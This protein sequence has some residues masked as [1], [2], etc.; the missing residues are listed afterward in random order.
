MAHAP[1]TWSYRRRN[2][3]KLEE[4]GKSQEEGAGVGLWATGKRERLNEAYWNNKDAQTESLRPPS[5]LSHQIK[6]TFKSKNDPRKK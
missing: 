5:N 4:H 6:P 1:W 3:T 2:Q